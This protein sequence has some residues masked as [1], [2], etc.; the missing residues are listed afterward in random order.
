MS[1]VTILINYENDCPIAEDDSIII[2]GSTSDS[3]IINV[4]ENDT[5]PDSEIDT[6]SVKIISGPTFGDAISNIDGSITYNYDESPI[7]FDTI[8]YSVSDYEGCETIGRV[9]IYIE[10]LLNPKYDLPNYFTPNGDDF[11]DYLMIKYEN[12]KMMDLSFEVKIMDRYQRLIY[13]GFV[14]SSDKIWDGINSFTSEIVKTDFYFY[15]I[16]PVEYYNTPYVRR[17]DKLLGTV[18]LEKER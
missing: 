5:D 6:T 11:N 16:T 13:E 3:R 2:D 8:T 4:L 15:E 12:I 17:R 9:Y 7:P 18:Y 10:N 14:Q 1:S